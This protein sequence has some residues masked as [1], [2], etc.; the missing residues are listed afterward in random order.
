M[1]ICIHVF[2]ACVCT[3]GHPKIG[4]L[5]GTALFQA[6]LDR[7]R[8][9]LS[10]SHAQKS[11]TKLK[12]LIDL[13]A[14]SS[15]AFAD[16]CCCLPSLVIWCNLF[17]SVNWW[18][19]HKNFPWTVQK[20]AASFASSMGSGIC[21]DCTIEPS[22]FRFTWATPRGHRLASCPLME[23]CRI[24]TARFCSRFQVLW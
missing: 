4:G 21:L 1:V 7:H 15:R 6:V 2:L 10:S 16:V 24:L 13:Q 22:R 17:T 11:K 14:P 20:R 19:V 23:H 3:M 8:G 5:Y 18:V 9:S 12:E